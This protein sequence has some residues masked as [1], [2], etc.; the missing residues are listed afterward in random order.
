MLETAEL[1]GM[2]CS[3][4]V[5]DRGANPQEEEEASRQLLVGREV[6]AA[7]ERIVHEVSAEEPIE[8][9]IKLRSKGGIIG[10][11]HRF[12][13]EHASVCDDVNCAFPSRSVCLLKERNELDLNSVETASTVSTHSRTSVE[14]SA[15]SACAGLSLCENCRKFGTRRVAG[16][17]GLSRPDLFVTRCELLH[18]ATEDDCWIFAR[19]SVYDV[20]N[21]FNEHPGGR[22]SLL[23]R[24]QALQDCEIDFDFHSK[25]GQGIWE[26][27]QVGR[28]IPCETLPGQIP[29]LETCAIL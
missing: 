19:D 29:D 15:S 10:A 26:T 3:S 17:R 9:E 4:C 25:R 18:H 5:A 12:R 13:E 27:M 24:S 2:E 21:Y 16:E 6:F 8:L 14:A 11:R 23:K 7:T 1:E 28:L 20:T 22:K